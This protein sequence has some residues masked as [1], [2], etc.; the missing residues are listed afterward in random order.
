[1]PVSNEERTLL[2]KFKESDGSIELAKM[3]PRDAELAFQLLGRGVIE[4]D[5]NDNKTTYKLRS[6]VAEGIT[7]TGTQS[8]EDIND[9]IRVYHGYCY[10]IGGILDNNEII[11]GKIQAL[12]QTHKF[13]SIPLADITI[14]ADWG[15]RPENPRQAKTPI[16]V[17]QMH[18]GKYV[19]LDGQ[20]RVLAKKEANKK[21][22]YASV[23]KVNWKPSYKSRGR[24]NFLVLGWYHAA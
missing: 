10:N 14:H 16:I 21:S 23:I 5:E 19:V 4:S 12:A 6:K 15:R 20:H 13:E 2:R 11:P 22:I 17:L 24:Q 9:A 7:F 8:K 3:E 1:M 18:N